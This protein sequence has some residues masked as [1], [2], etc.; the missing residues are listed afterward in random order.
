MW[1]GCFPLSVAFNISAQHRLCVFLWSHQSIHIV[2]KWLS[3]GS[4]VISH[5]HMN[6]SAPEIMLTAY[7]PSNSHCDEWGC[8]QIQVNTTTCHELFCS[9]NSTIKQNKVEVHVSWSP[10][11]ETVNRLAG[12][13]CS[14]CL[15]WFLISEHKHEH[16]AQ[17][18]GVSQRPSWQNNQALQWWMIPVFTSQWKLRPVYGYEDFPAGAKC[19]C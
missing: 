1:S 12:F 8:K 13:Q 5:M 4:R 14:A 16:K 18:G 17:G 3:C 10:L 6:L 15:D 9:S 11:A 2:I 7:I 19:F